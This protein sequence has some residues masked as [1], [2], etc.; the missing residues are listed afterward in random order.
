MLSSSIRKGWITLCPKPN[1]LCEKESPHKTKSIPGL[2]TKDNP[3]LGNW[4]KMTS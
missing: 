3:C 4:P 2:R 1:S